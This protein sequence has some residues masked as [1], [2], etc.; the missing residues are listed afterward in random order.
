MKLKLIS[1][2]QVMKFWQYDVYPECKAEKQ[3]QDYQ[4]KIRGNLVKRKVK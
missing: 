2:L 4:T 3:F 1:I